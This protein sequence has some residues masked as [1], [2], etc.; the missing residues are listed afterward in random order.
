MI[1]SI[2]ELTSD[3]L[4]FDIGAAR[5]GVGR[6]NPIARLSE[7]LSPIVVKDSDPF[8]CIN[9]LMT[10]TS[11]SALVFGLPRNLNGDSTDQTRAVEKFVHSY[12]KENKPTIP[13][14]FIDEAGT[15]KEADQRIG[16]RTGEL[17]RDSVAACIMLEDFVEQRDISRLLVSRS[18]N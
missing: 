5:I 16:K 3:I 12:I 7:P 18:E 8:K 4:G 6:I 15:S 13:V 10:E 2:N 14:Y 17:S 11:A 1:S 9:N